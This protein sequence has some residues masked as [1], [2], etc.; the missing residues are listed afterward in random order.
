MTCTGDNCRV[1][2]VDDGNASLSSGCLNNS[3]TCQSMSVCCVYHANTSGCQ[4]LG[5]G[6]RHVTSQQS[7]ACLC[8]VERFGDRLSSNR[9]TCLSL[10]ICQGCCV[11][12]GYGECGSTQTGCH[13]RA[14]N[15][16]CRRRRDTGLVDY[17]R[18]ANRR[19]GTLWNLT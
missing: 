2:G 18:D 11:R 14:V 6:N 9:G 4:R 1:G 3:R 8:G 10:C 19:V 17:R 13:A 12:C 15:R 16:R 7:R 5:T